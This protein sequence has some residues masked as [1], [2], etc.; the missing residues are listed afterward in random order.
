MLCFL[1]LWYQ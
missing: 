1:C